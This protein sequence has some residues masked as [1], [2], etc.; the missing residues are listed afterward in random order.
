[1]RDHATGRDAEKRHSLCRWPHIVGVVFLLGAAA[2]CSGC[3]LNN[4]II[5]GSNPLPAGSAQMGAG[6]AD[7]SGRATQVA[8][9]SACAPAYGYAHDPAKLR[10]M[11]L[12]YEA[13]Q[14]ATHEQLA[15][16][17]ASYDSTYQGISELGSRK[18]SYCSSKDGGEVLAD[19]RRYQSGYFEARAPVA[20]EGP[21]DWKKTRDSINCAGRC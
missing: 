6:S 19:L 21:D 10:T 12:N 14:G 1:M 11:Y 9:I 7:V 2:L 4:G 20:T 15:S 8:F 5:T 17:E 16:I 3:S 18:P 13:R